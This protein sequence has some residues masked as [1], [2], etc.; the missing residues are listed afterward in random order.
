MPTNCSERTFRTLRVGGLQIH[1]RDRRIVDGKT[2]TILT[3]LS[4][5]F[6]TSLINA[7]PDPANIATLCDQVWKTPHVSPEAIAQRASQL[8]QALG[9]DPKSPRYIRT[10]RGGGY[11]LIPAVE[12]LSAAPPEVVADKPRRALIA[13]MVGIS[14]TLIAGTWVWRQVDQP[15]SVI[16]SASPQ[17]TELV[18]RADE[19]RL[20]GSLEDTQISIE[21]YQQ[22]LEQDP[23]Q[24]QAL[25]GLSLSLAHKPSKYDLDLKFAEQAASMADRALVLDPTSSRAWAARGLADDA[26]GWISSAL[27]YYE[28]ALELNPDYPGLISSIAYL[29]QVRGQL[30]KSLRMEARALSLAPPTYFADYQI[31]TT[32]QLAG[33]Q[34]PAEAWLGRATQLRPDNVFLLANRARRLM[35]QNRLAEALV[36]LE[37]AQATRVFHHF[38]R[39]LTLRSLGHPEQAKTAFRQGWTQADKQGQRCLYCVAMLASDGDSDAETT[40]QRWLPSVERPIDEK[41]HWPEVFVELAM[42]AAALGDRPLA[43]R[44]LDEA[45]SLGFT[46]YSWLQQLP[47]LEDVLSS[48]SGQRLLSEMLRHQREQNRLISNDPELNELLKESD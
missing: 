3:D 21:I 40:A 9:D 5:R 35:L 46:D 4:W 15:N 26:R 47:A 42:L 11:Q 8:R 34:G 13:G 41:Q 10:I 31:A 43:L 24:L 17:V 33:L 48:A 39:G 37:S 28:R 30:H 32:L 23:D 38:L 1:E 7:S 36:V 16:P 29:Y 27:R 6:L 20:R 44:Y 2:S 45:R 25:I 19:Y 22:V 12:I 18:R 14:L